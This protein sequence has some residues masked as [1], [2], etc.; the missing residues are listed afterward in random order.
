MVNKNGSPQAFM[1][2]KILSD[3]LTCYLIGTELNKLIAIYFIL[4]LHITVTA[5]LY[6]KLNIDD[7]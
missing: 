3:G 7:I 6:T 2:P 5:K 1:E 4:A